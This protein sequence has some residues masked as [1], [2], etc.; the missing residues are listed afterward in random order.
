MKQEE[1]KNLKSEND[2]QSAESTENL[3]KISDST[4]KR[5]ILLLNLLEKWGKIYITSKE[6]AELLGVKDSLIRYDFS[7]LN[8]PQE[9]RG[10][11]NGY[12]VSV[13]E[14]DIRNAISSGV[15]ETIES[16]LQNNILNDNK[17]H[18]CIVGLGRLGAALLDDTFFENSDFKICAGFDSSLNRVE[19][20]RSTFELFPASKIETVCPAKKIEYAIL[21]CQE[22]EVQ[23]MADRLVSAG[24]KGIVN[25]TNSVF[26]A[27]KTVKVQNVSPMV[28]LSLV[29]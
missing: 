12:E 21:C 15:S 19:L 3:Q 22:S 10:Y 20:L 13:L 18:V 25:Y 9:H 28:A 29:E 14:Q 27:P 5:M 24:I 26:L 8:L 16:N 1:D 17:K 4:K 23:K 11:K 6:I 7:V 2:L